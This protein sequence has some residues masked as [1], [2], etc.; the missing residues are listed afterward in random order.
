MIWVAS[1]RT[2]ALICHNHAD[3]KNRIPI[4]DQSGPGLTLP[5]SGNVGQKGAGGNGATVEMQMVGVKDEAV[6]FV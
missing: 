6:G 3:H 4:P 5:A 1:I 2:F